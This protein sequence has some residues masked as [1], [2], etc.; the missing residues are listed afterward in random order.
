MTKN[1]IDPINAE[2]K[3]LAKET[4]LRDHATPT[5]LENAK[6]PAYASENIES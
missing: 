1:K 2:D 6:N 5:Q 3:G 4:E